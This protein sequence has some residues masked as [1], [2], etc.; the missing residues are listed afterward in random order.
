MGG[1]RNG[2]D[3]GVIW[4]LGIREVWLGWDVEEVEQEVMW[5]GYWPGRVD[6]VAVMGCGRGELKW[7]RGW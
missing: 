4:M 5:R 2:P 1:G 7:F 6:Y 3:T